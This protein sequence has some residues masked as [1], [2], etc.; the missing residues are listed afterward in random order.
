[1][2]VKLSL[3]LLGW[4]YF[5]YDLCYHFGYWQ[6]FAEV[7]DLIAIFGVVKVWPL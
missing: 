1:M 3:D 4:V 5:G 2:V 6:G 7:F